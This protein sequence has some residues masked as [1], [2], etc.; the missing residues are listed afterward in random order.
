MPL[1]PSVTNAVRDYLARRQNAGVPLDDAAG[2]FWHERNGRYSRGRISQL[3][4]EVLR[5][6]GLKPAHGRVGP[7]VH[8]LRHAMVCN[9]M[10]SWYQQ[11]INP[12]SH[13]PH[14]A[15]YLG[16]KSID[17]TLVYLHITQELMQIASNRFRERS[18]RILKDQENRA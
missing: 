13:L 14:L 3:L 12:Q 2:L 16:H 4:V 18:A 17:S 10:L 15:T 8:D 5:R 9:R 1:T 11:G 7:R 6:A